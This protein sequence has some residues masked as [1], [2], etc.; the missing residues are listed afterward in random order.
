MIDEIDEIGGNRENSHEATGKITGVLLKKLDGMER[1]SNILLVG[2]TN[3]K[4]SLDPALISRFKYSQYF[5][6]P[7]EIEIS[8][9]VSYYLPEL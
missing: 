6:L 4:D 8:K 7:N 2:A 3:R 5:R 9:I 1:I